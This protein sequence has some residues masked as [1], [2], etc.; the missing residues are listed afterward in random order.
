MKKRK[1]IILIKLLILKRENILLNI[2]I[3]PIVIIT[4]HRYQKMNNFWH[5]EHLMIRYWKYTT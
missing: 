4:D 3:Q 5:M 1:I 2:L